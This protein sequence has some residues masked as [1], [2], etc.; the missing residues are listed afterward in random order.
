LDYFFLFFLS[1]HH[2]CELSA[3]KLFISH[4]KI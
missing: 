2:S 4:C 1:I 3:K